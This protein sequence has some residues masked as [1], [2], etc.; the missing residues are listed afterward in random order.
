VKAPDE[1]TV[2]T[3]ERQLQL[4]C[5]VVRGLT[6]LGIKLDDLITLTQQQNDLV[7][8]LLERSGSEI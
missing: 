3:S 6:D 1:I 5:A 7:R 8:R 2:S 4:L